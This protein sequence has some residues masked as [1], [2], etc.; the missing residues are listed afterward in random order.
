MLVGSE[1]FSKSW[2]VHCNKSVLA[3]ESSY[4]STSSETSDS[5]DVPINGFLFDLDIKYLNFL[6]ASLETDVSKEAQLGSQGFFE[7]SDGSYACVHGSSNAPSFLLN[8]KGMPYLINMD[9][10]GVVVNPEGGHAACIADGLGSGGYFSAYVA[11][12]ICKYFLKTC[13]AKS[14]DFI[15]N[16]GRNEQVADD[17]FDDCANEVEYHSP[18][19]LTGSSTALFVNCVPTDK[20]NDKQMYRIWVTAL[21]DCAAIH[22]NNEKKTACQLNKIKRS[23]TSNGKPDVK[24][25]GGHIRSDGSMRHPENIVVSTIE[26]TEDDFLVLVTDGFL[27]NVRENKVNEVI[28]LVAFTSL[29]DEPF[30]KLAT[31]NRFWECPEDSTLP[32]FDDLV[33]FISINANEKEFSPKR[34]TTSQITKRLENY[35]K[36]VTYYRSQM[37]ENYYKTVPKQTMGAKRKDTSVSN[38]DDKIPK[39]DDYMII[40]MNPGSCNFA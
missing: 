16:S 36:L 40:T 37:E 6:P 30:E 27:D 39:T 24:S 1:N 8:E 10:G 13:S 32:T 26:A 4:S 5:L 20:R 31:Y 7:A 14:C 38:R 18:N 22:I 35:I 33:K 9:R 29:F 3:E 2:P 15:W 11:H 34:P 17:L 28:G 23:L 21:G 12:I 25:T 19:F